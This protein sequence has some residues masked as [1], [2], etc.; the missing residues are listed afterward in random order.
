M[1]HVYFAFRIFAWLSHFE[2]GKETHTKTPSEL[3]FLAAFVNCEGGGED[4]QKPME[5]SVPS[6]HCACS[7]WWAFKNTL[8]K[9]DS[10]FVIV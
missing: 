2:Q 6:E 4:I 8:L 10:V 5:I 9:R 1:A 3:I 7:I